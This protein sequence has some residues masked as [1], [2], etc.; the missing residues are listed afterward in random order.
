MV[1]EKIYKKHSSNFIAKF[2]LD[3][4]VSHY[5][6]N[7]FELNNIKSNSFLFNLIGFLLLI[8]VVLFEVIN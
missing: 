8:N 7:K 6:K 3:Y 5:L 1:R 4:N 2:Y